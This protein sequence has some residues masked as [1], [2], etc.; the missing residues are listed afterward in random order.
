MTTPSKILSV[1]AA[2]LAWSLA[3]CPMEAA[4][5]H[6][7]AP[8]DAHDAHDAHEGEEEILVQATRSGRRVQDEVIRV[9]VINREEIEEKLLMTPGN[10]SMLVA[11]TPGVRV[12]LSSAALGSSNIRMQGMAGRYTQLLSDGLPLYGGQPSS[13]GLLQI[14]PTDLGQVEVIKGSA[15][16]LY[17]PSALGG[18][19]NLVSRRP[20][21]EAQAE[22]LFNLTSRDGQDIT[23]YGALPLSPNISASLTGGYHR[24]T[25]QD[26]DDDGWIDMPG[27]ERWTVRP[28][29]FWEG[30]DGANLL[31]TAGAM[32]EDRVGGTLP[33]QDM[34]DGQPFPLTQD[35]RR[36][37]AGLLTEIPIEGI[38]TLHARASVMAQR[39]RQHFGTDRDTS[40][41]T[42]YFGEVS[43]GGTQGATSWR[44]GTALQADR[45]RSR[46]F[47]SFDYR[48]TAPALF[49]Q[50]E[51]ELSDDILLAASARA[52]FHSE[53]GTHL[54]P[55]LSALYRPGAW[56]VRASVGKGFY[57]PT[58]FVDAI[59]AAGLARLEP[60]GNL[61]AETA[62]TAALDLG[63]AANGLEA[64]VTLFASDIDHGLQLQTVDTDRVRLI[65]AD[66]TTRTRGAELMLRYRWQSF[67]LTGSY[68]LVD[69]HEPA[70]SGA[71]RRPVPRTPR[72]TAGLVGM[73]EEHGKGRVGIE[74][75]YTGRQP[76]DDNPYR[77]H[78]RPYFELGALAEIVLGRISLFV[79][80]ENILDIRQTKYD[81]LPLP[82]RAPDGRWT[83]DAWGPIDGF[84]VNG[85]VR[86]KFGAGH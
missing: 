7:D 11:E 42:T 77:T 34:P 71:G 29:L 66:G 15:S 56:T 67:S 20:R 86:F 49:G 16:A 19:I 79:N 35:S 72:H 5:Q 73:W 58:P 76:L 30:D 80:A 68:V 33:G 84:V 36:Y 83:V 53:Y 18:V 27:Y 22:M 3:L 64:N 28:R 12:Q 37:D 23:G 6:A 60:L 51:Q 32:T 57:A 39:H 54:S 45:Y 59:E 75:Y 4:A 70:P 62:T 25:R 31:L 65:N 52:D 13:I 26:L 63:Y 44:A 8:S 21:A 14:P 41:Q 81:P 38:G 78:S 10:I 61:K 24:Q 17:G 82:A 48:Y 69:A 55:R 74:A 50:V 2:A 46:A 40:R 1:A 85:G 43:L 9:D 47:P